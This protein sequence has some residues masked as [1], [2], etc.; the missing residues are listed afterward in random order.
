MR[1]RD[2]CKSPSNV[3]NLFNEL[4]LCRSK[5]NA[6]WCGS[7]MFSWMSTNQG[8]SAMIVAQMVEMQL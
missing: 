4:F 6:V 8:I 1:N 5:S 7:W 3:Q 2:H